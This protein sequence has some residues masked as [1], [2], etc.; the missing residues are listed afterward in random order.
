MA[1]KMSLGTHVAT[2]SVGGTFGEL[3]LMYGAPRNATVVS[4]EDNCCLWALDR[5]T[6]RRILMDGAFRKRRMYE[7]FLKEVPL[8]E[9]LQDYERNKVADALESVTYPSGA[10]II[11]EGDVGDSFYL[12]ESGEAAAYKKGLE[13]AVRHYKK[14][15]FFG[16]LALLDDKPRAASVVC[17]GECKVA[18]LGREGFRRLLGPVESLLRRTR[19]GE[20]EVDP[21]SKA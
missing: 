21:L 17:E 13:R 7:G 8:L 18:R 5:V 14:G 2:I 1:D 16:E 20:E 11:S 4:Q 19:Y 6:F 3:A 10:T 9:G 12:L 15:D